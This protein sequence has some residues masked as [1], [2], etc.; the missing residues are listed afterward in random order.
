[1][2][3]CV[4]SSWGKWALCVQDSA[5]SARSWSSTDFSVRSLLSQSLPEQP[6]TE[7]S[8][9]EQETAEQAVLE[10]PRKASQNLDTLPAELFDMIASYLDR[11]GLYSL[12]LVSQR[13]SKLAYPSILASL[14]ARKHTGLTP[15]EIENIHTLAIDPTIN[16]LP[17]SLHVTVPYIGYSA[18]RKVSWGRLSYDRKAL[19]ELPE[20][21]ALRQDLNRLVNCK[22]FHFTLTR[23]ESTL[24]NKIMYI[25]DALYAVLAENTVPVEKLILD[26]RVVKSRA[27]EKSMMHPNLAR[28]WRRLKSLKITESPS[29]DFSRGTA[30]SH[31]LQHAPELRSLSLHSLADTPARRS[32]IFKLASSAN[33][34]TNRLEKLRLSYLTVEP[35]DLIMWLTRFNSTLRIL[36]LQSIGLAHGSWVNVV[37]HILDSCPNLQK[38]VVDYP[39]VS[40][41]NR[42]AWDKFE[43]SG[44]DIRIK[45]EQFKQSATEAKI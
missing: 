21:K 2:G 37:Q 25:E 15:I 7:P 18:A 32:T 9:P 36:D 24:E 29:L 35:E 27:N 31:I 13:V 22:E 5:T 43:C 40:E 41:W 23:A 14:H 45:L 8:S 10:E 30:L 3:N 38:V 42:R 6:S 20:M 28:V 4:S 16:H 19:H 17:R 1:M 12:Y 34:R 26:S 11:D 44:P 33:I 39:W